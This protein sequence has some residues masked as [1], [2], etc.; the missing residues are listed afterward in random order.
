[1]KSAAW[2]GLALF[3][4][5][6][7]YNINANFL[8][9]TARDLGATSHGVGLIQGI[10]LAGAALALLPILWLG[11]RFSRRSILLTAWGAGA[12]GTLEVALARSFSALIP[13]AFLMLAGGAA[14]PALAALATEVAPANSR[15]RAIN[16]IFGAL[17]VGLLAGSAV[18]GIIA[19]HLGNQALYLTS[20]SL[21]LGAML[22]LLPVPASRGAAG[23]AA[24]RE[25]PPAGTRPWVKLLLL[26][27]PAGIAYMVLSLP[28]SFL[29]TYLREQAGLSLTGTGFVTAVL[30]VGQVGWSALFAVWPG[31]TGQAEVG[32][33]PA[34][35]RFGQGTLLA[36][37]VCLAANA[38][39]G[40]L[41]PAGGTVG[42]VIALLLRGALFSLQPLGLALVSELTGTGAGLTGRYS[43]LAL[44]M[45][46]AL[47]AAPVAAGFIYAA[48]P[49][50]PFAIAGA[51]AL[52]GTLVLIALRA[53]S[54]PVS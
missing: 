53:V 21:S 48:H 1:V 22:A 19:Q 9:L 7:A 41:F 6:A 39:F 12:A 23:T 25:D 54:R 10:A 47:A 38:L 15:R 44:V 2:L 28:S 17:P 29:T 27:I 40:L 24:G 26:G 3:L 43:L 50:W 35:F 8:P 45:A 52:A 42:A 16:G 31:E 4:W 14:V 51:A 46:A 13:G 5:S 30:A 18:G 34:R 49:T 37:T 20:A 11:D 32:L 36:L 33:G